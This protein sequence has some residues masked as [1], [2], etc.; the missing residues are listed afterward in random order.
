MSIF[1][2]VLLLVVLCM[3]GLAVPLTLVGQFLISDLGN[4]S[5]HEK[6]N[7]CSEVVQK[8]VDTIMQSQM[9]F[10]TFLEENEELA[11]AIATGDAAWVRSFAQTLV[12]NPQVDLVTICDLEGKVL[13]RGHSDKAGDLL[14]PNRLS[15]N[16]PLTQGKRIIGIE[17]GNVVKLTMA[18]GVPIRH[19]GKIVGAAIIGANLSSDA[20]VD[21]IKK[22]LNVECTIFLG[23]TRVATTVIRDGKR[24]IDT[25]LDNQEIYDKV[26]KMGEKVVTRNTING[27]EYDTEYWAWKDMSGKNA[28]MF[29]VGIS[30]TAMLAEQVKA[31]IYFALAALAIT[32]LM[33][34]IGVIVA[35]AIS[36]PLRL[37]TSYAEDVAAGNFSGTLTVTTTDEV[38]TLAKALS[39]MVGNLKAR[40]Q[41]SEEKSQEAAA[42]T[43]K[44]TAAVIEASTAKEKAEEGQK[45]ILAAAENVEQV[46]TRLSTAVEQIRTQVEMSAASTETQRSKVISSSAA[47]EEMN[48]TVMEVARSASTASQGAER[49]RDKAQ[50][51]SAIVK[52]S[53]SAINGV[54][55]ET[56]SL[57]SE[58]NKLGAQ[59]EGIGAIMTVISDI[60]DQTNLL[61]LNAAIEAARAGDAGRGFAVVADEVRK[62]AEKTMN[63]TKEVAGA[64]QGIQKSTKESM[65]AV[66]RTG[67]NLESTTTLVTR[68]GES[69]AEIVTE[70]VKMA[71]QVRGIA[72]S[73]EEQSAVS[74]EITRSLAEI[75]SSASDTATAM[76]ES[77]QAV[78]NLTSQAHELQQLVHKLRNG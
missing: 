76:R 36:R 3:I 26:T 58:M 42:Q 45:A 9:T 43:E 65:S 16:V 27:T 49:A 44:A 29:F 32:L 15:S 71:D 1:K 23:D 5:A 59:A 55:A 24:F 78:S 41:D 66:D 6:L 64:I 38:G 37:A 22:T 18:S 50:E 48:S 62:L 61:A 21:A 46:V 12:A 35:R 11:A 28:G 77:T 54:Q 53:I 31:I 34:G 25:K 17:P 67:A 51:G 75:N 33:I 13:A 19:Q 70:S 72:A 14:G 10:G 7:I 57:R 52:N 47:M 40:I 39:A 74:E 56:E 68:S 4:D 20:F 8:E 2:K 60:A 30:R 69:L 73:S 63:A